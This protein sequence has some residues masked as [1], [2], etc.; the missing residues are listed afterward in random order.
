M[1]WLASPQRQ[2]GNP[3]RAGKRFVP[4]RRKPPSKYSEGLL[5]FATV[6]AG[7]E[8][9]AVELGDELHADFLRAGGFAL[10]V[11]AAVAE[12]FAVHLLDHVARPRV[13]FGMA[14]R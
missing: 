12:T 5:V 3:L 1:E 14:L 8:V 4:L 6:K 10:V 9:F 2:Q 11:V 7:G 13:P